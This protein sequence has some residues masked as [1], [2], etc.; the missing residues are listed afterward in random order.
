MIH[1]LRA[2]VAAISSLPALALTA[3]LL[4]APVGAAWADDR[5]TC[6]DGDDAVAVPACQR[7]VRAD[8]SDFSAFMALGDAL[9]RLER[10]AEAS[11]AYHQAVSLEPG[12][13]RA[14]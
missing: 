14:A 8:P 12:N 4:L 5:A 2:T 11:E 13:E 3:L 7:V 6:I 9:V 10:L 1:R